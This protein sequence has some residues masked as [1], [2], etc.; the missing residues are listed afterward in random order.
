MRVIFYSEAVEVSK[1]NSLKKR[2]RKC[3]YKTR[4]LI[5]LHLN[6]IFQ[7]LSG[8]NMNVE[9]LFQEIKWYLITKIFQN[10]SLFSAIIIKYYVHCYSV[11]N[12]TLYE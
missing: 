9:D 12:P 7:S 4:S 6:K 5:I 3:I 2:K 10:K 1:S 11:R 8:I